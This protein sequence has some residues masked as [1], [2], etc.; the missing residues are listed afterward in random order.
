M[1]AGSLL[2]SGQHF[3]EHMASLLGSS[4]R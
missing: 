1:G 4:L 2:S 3:L